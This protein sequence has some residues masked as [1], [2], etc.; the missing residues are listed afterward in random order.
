MK[1]TGEILLAASCIGRNLLRSS[2]ER[3][4]TGSRYHTGRTSSVSRGRQR[5][6]A[7]VPR[8]SLQ[9]TNMN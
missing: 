7:I 6:D 9:V 4:P 1:T 3:F 5:S 8:K 2:K